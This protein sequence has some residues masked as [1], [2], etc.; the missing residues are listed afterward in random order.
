MQPIVILIGVASILGSVTASAV[1]CPATSMVEYQASSLKKYQATIT[2]N[3][4][5]GNTRTFTDY[6]EAKG[7][8]EAQ[9]IFEGRYPHD[10]VSGVREVR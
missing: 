10:R 2:R 4:G 6:C 3:D 5:R 9:R 8:L 1:Q 7:V